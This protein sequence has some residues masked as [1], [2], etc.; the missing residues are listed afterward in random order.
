MVAVGRG[1]ERVLVWCGKRGGMEGEGVNCMDFS[2]CVA[3][4]ATGAHLTV[5][6]QYDNFATIALFRCH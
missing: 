4:G 2:M 5:T 6:E 1:I 3:E